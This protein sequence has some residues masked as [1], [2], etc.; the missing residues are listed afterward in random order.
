M[1]KY[2]IPSLKR[3]FSTHEACLEYIFNLKHSKKCQCGGKYLPMKDVGRLIRA[4]Q[5]SKC[6]FKISPTAGTILHKSKTPLP[7]WFHAILVFSNAK[8]GFSAQHMERSL[9]VTYKC[10]YRILSQIRKTL[11]QDNIKLKGDVE[12]D[13]GYFGGKGNAG[14]NNERLSR[15]MAKKIVVIVAVEREGHA[16]A[17][18]VPDS[19]SHTMTEFIRRNI[20]TK[21]TN[22]L[23]DSSKV[24]LRSDKTHDRYSVD[25]HKGEYVRDDIHIN[26]V[27]TFFAHLKRSIRGTFKS[28]SRRHFQSYLDAFVFHYNNR[29]NDKERFSSLLGMLLQSSER[30]ETRI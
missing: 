2:G 15:V 20:E 14:A 12:I 9:E 17:E 13:I 21:L 11:K 5:C 6:R 29:Y 4:F 1:R 10:A 19:S 8:S 16:K 30:Q 25:H 3:E 18:V 27:E 28:L 26:T 22:T 7:L 23:T 24:Y